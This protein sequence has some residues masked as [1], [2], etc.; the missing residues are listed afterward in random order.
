MTIAASELSISRVFDPD[1]YG[2]GDPATF[3]LSVSTPD[4]R[5]APGVQLR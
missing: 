3:G 5:R 4:A 2:S 1:V